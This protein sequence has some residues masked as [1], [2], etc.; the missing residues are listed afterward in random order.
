M[1]LTRVTLVVALVIR[2]L[3]VPFIIDLKKR[4][5]PVSP[6]DFSSNC[7]GASLKGMAG[8]IV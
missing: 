8:A 5:W 4:D 1:L 3:D 7:A 6:A 2:F